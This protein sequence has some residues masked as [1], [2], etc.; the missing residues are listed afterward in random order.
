[1]IREI[2]H[3]ILTGGLSNTLEIAEKMG[4]QEE[5]LN[6]ILQLLQARGYLRLS[7]CTEDQMIP[8]SN[9]PTSGSCIRTAQK[10]QTFIITERGKKFAKPKRLEGSVT[11]N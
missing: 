3:L 1:M 5:T 7:E 11:G 10:G 4:I 2:L 6:D 8:C 9:C